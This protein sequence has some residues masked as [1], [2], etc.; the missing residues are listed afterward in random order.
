MQIGDGNGNGNGNGEGT[1]GDWDLHPTVTDASRRAAGAAVVDTGRRVRAG[2]VGPG[3]GRGGKEL[4]EGFKFDPRA[5][6]EGAP[7]GAQLVG[8]GGGRGPSSEP[9]IL[10]VSVERAGLFETK[11]TP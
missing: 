11:A 8:G 4:L 7:V 3:V 10:N 2:M 5:G 6:A 9:K 1:S